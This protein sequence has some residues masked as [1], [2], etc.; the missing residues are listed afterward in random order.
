M[1]PVCSVVIPTRNCLSYLACALDS[2]RIQDIDGLEVIVVDDGSTDGTGRWLRQLAETWPRLRVIDGPARGPSHARNLAIAAANADLT[3]FLDADDL[4]WPAK[5]ARQIAHHQAHLDVGFSFT[6]YLHV[7]VDGGE[8]GTC[9]DYW[10]FR[11]DGARDGSFTVLRDGEAAILGTN[12]VGTSTVVVRTRL[13]QIANGFAENWQS[14]E[15][16]DLWLRLSSMA[17]ASATTDVLATYLMHRPGNQTGMAAKRLEAVAGIVKRYDDR[18]EPAFRRASRKARARLH[19]AR[20]DL[21]G[22]S[23]QPV[24]S[25]AWR[26]RALSI[27][28]SLRTARAAAGQARG[29][30][31]GLLSR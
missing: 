15:D 24:R 5:L 23:H 31:R 3:A 21:A 4:W 28:P 25:L 12:P 18:P 16:L 20:A 26:L 14:A 13:L 17:P 30:A 10:H 9:F 19:E 22:A 8:H 11:P 29:M 6:D 27:A 1:R 7:D 2:V